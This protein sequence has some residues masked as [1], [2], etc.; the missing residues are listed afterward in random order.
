MKKTIQLLLIVLLGQVSNAHVTDGT[1]ILQHFTIAKHNVD[2]YFTMLKNN[3]V[4]IE[5]P[6]HK[7]VHYPLS[8]FESTQQQN[9]TM[10]Y[11][12]I[13]T[14]NAPIVGSKIIVKH[15]NYNFYLIVEI[16]MATLF[17]LLA[18][19]FYKSYSFASKLKY[20]YPILM[21]GV[22]TVLIS[23]DK[24]TRA[25]NDPTEM[26]KAFIPFKPSVYTHWDA[27]WFYIESKGIPT[28]HGMMVGI[29]SNGWQQQVPLPHC[30]T[31]ASAW[32]IPLN[33]TNTTTPVAVNANHFTKGAI[34]M[35][36]NG[37][38]I[39]NP[40]TN[41][42]ADAFLTGQLDN[43]GG[44]CGRGD[45]YHYHTA[46]LHLYANTNDTLPI[47]YALDGYAVRGAKEHDGTA[48]AALDAN[49]GHSYG[50]V[51]HYHG[52]A[53]APYM[54]G[55]MV[56]IVTEDANKQI[57]PQ[58]QGQPVRTEN[59]TPLNGAL[60]TA[61]TPNGTN[62]GYNLTYTLN[63]TSGYA[64]NYS[65]SGTTYTFN[66]VTPSGTSTK[67]YTGPN[68][69]ACNLPNAIK[70]MITFNDDIKLYP[71]PISNI[72]QIDLGTNIAT[73]EVSKILIVN[74]QGTVIYS[75]NIFKNK[76]ELQNINIGIYYILMQIGGKQFSKMI[77]K[78]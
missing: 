78:K 2:G 36:V 8:S 49:H 7:M 38:P 9:I 63:G 72:L 16:I 31:G 41:T 52:S 25:T 65:W 43:F 13:I 70:N 19:R 4:Y 48:M 39:F 35:A 73:K 12:K 47:A 28:T 5:T 15:T 45:D 54:I 22:A 21:V 59:W 66:Y 24:K 29:G 76:I 62:D 33:P 32:Q 26:D 6:Q 55:N 68:L 64:I 20:V 1:G 71:N 23:A 77:E 42:G 27:T 37:I 58:P 14:A 51:Y 18:F 60:I 50:G 74:M 53:A 10:R 40:F 34:A 3:E 44:H 11:A 30:Y 57:I 75:S 61:C 46:P 56:G 67:T 69:S 17:I